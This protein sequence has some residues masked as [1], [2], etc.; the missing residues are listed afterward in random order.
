M[1]LFQTNHNQI[2]GQAH[3]MYKIEA[4]VLAISNRFEIA[5]FLVYRNDRIQGVNQTSVHKG[6][7]HIVFFFNFIIRR[8]LVKRVC[9]VPTACSLLQAVFAS[10]IPE[11]TELAAQRS[12][13]GGTYSK[14]VRRRYTPKPINETHRKPLKSKNPFVCSQFGQSTVTVIH[15][16]K[17]EYVF[18]CYYVNQSRIKLHTIQFQLHETFNT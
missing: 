8:M 14:D 7:V 6:N 1:F 9:S 17:F 4:V 16:N 11:I 5:F 18:K 10:W 15:I 3:E 13:Y 12:K 2:Q